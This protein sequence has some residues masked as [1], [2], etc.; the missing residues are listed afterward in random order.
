MH[1][2]AHGSK[3]A[4]GTQTMTAHAKQPGF[5]F[6]DDEGEGALWSAL[7]AGLVGC[8]VPLGRGIVAGWSAPR[9]MLYLVLAG[10]FVLLTQCPV[11]P[12]GIFRALR[13]PKW[14]YLAVMGMLGF[15]LQWI[16]ADP[17]LQPIVFTIPFVDAALRFP[18]RRSAFVGAVYLGLMGTGLWLG[19]QR[20]P[21]SFLFPTAAFGALMGFMY[22]FTRMATRQATARK[23]ADLLAVDLA[24]QRDYLQRLIETTATLTRDLDLLQVLE[25]VAAEGRALAHAGAAR[26]WLREQT[27]DSSTGPVLRLAAIVPNPSTQDR[28]DEAPMF[29]GDSLVLGDALVLPLVTRGDHIGALEFRDRA[30][31]P[32]TADDARLLQPF[33]GVAAAAIENARLYEQARESATLAERNRLARELHDTIAQGLTAVGMQLEAAQR[34]F[35]RA[36]D[37][38]RAR[39]A[40]AAELTRETLEDVR[41]S[42]WTLA[43]PLIDGDTLRAAVDDL[44]RQ[45]AARTHLHIDYQHSGTAPVLSHGAATQVLRIVQEAL[46]NVEKH[47]AASHVTI[48]S[49]TTASE[50]CVCVRDDGRGFD[51]DTLARHANNGSGFGLLSLRERARLAGGTVEVTSSPGA[52]TCVSIVIATK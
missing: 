34:S 25:Q 14:I 4:P 30:K 10:L 39:L 35:D 42:V 43:S 44:S 46:Q 21:E 41:R 52:G 48:V 3:L 22:A 6:A 12:F 47:A 16:S 8:G 27:F 29:A 32:F 15:L 17:F 19:G 50:T 13:Q 2:H 24:E 20:A 33:A 28:P 23:Q 45:F 1:T 7:L 31:A 49:T 40:R 36:P 26:V 37:R 38:T 51:P 9:T 11:L 18:P 5:N